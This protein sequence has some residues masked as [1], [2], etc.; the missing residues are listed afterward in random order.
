MKPD[1]KEMRDLSHETGYNRGLG[2]VLIMRLGSGPMN[3]GTLLAAGFGLVVA[4]FAAGMF[5]TGSL[6]FGTSQ[7]TYRP[8]TANGDAGLRDWTSGSQADEAG[9]PRVSGLGRLQPKDGVVSLG[10]VVGEEVERI[11]VEEG[12]KVEKGTVL[13]TYA[14]RELRAIELATAQAELEMA[15]GKLKSELD[16]ARARTRLARVNADHAKNNA[17]EIAAQEKEIAARKASVELA[18]K[19]LER[20]R[21]LSESLVSPQERERLNVSLRKAEAELLA[22]EARLEATRESQELRRQTADADLGVA[23]ANEALV[24]ASKEAEVRQKAVDAAEKRLE[25][26]QL[27]APAAGTVLRVLTHP[28]EATGR[29]PVLRFADLGHMICVAEVYQTQKRLVREGQRVL[30]ESEAFHPPRN[31]RGKGL[32]GTVTRVGKSVAGSGLTP[33]DPSQPVDRRVF[34]VFVTIDEADVPEA[35]EFVNL[36]VGV[37]IFDQGR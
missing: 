31:A 6:P 29:E 19:D 35:A 16:V 11:L 15:T 33:F 5:W 13:A 21:G 22:S 3:R 25:R 27:K 28:G 37:V 23:E 1:V 17:S 8:F 32:S 26:S 24:E 30:I 2:E 20:T 12:T 7:R 14:S 10:L 36:Q 4:G 34:E 9:T 18:R